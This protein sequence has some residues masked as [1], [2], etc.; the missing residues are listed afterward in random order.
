MDIY[1]LIIAELAWQLK[2]TCHVQGKGWKMQISHDIYIKIFANIICLGRMDQIPFPS[3]WWQWAAEHDTHANTHTGLKYIAPNQLKKQ[4]SLK[5]RKK[6]FG[7][8][9]VMF[10]II[11]PSTPVTL[12]S[13]HCLEYIKRS[14][15]WNEHFLIENLRSLQTPAVKRWEINTAIML[16]L[17]SKTALVKR[18]SLWKDSELYFPVRNPFCLII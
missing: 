12:Y 14:G 8:L 7:I 9:P 3:T 13:L 11:W 6:D 18:L 16:W 4:S 2:S 5:I 17:L 10:L 15:L 1:S